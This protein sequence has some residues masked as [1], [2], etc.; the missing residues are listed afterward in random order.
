MTPFVPTAPPIAPT[1]GPLPPIFTPQGF[2]VP[3]IF[4]FMPPPPPP[5]AAPYILPVTTSNFVDRFLQASV[6]ATSQQNPTGYSYNGGNG[7]YN[8]SIFRDAG[9]PLAA[10][11]P[12]A[13][14]PVFNRRNYNEE[15]MES[16]FRLEEMSNKCDRINTSLNYTKKENY[17][18]FDHLKRF[19]NILQ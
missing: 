10:P 7:F 11:R 2:E 16:K 9:T 6:D 14:S 3:P 1:H 15:Q 5:M 19:Y 17:Q 18:Q 8:Y 4:S 12:P 13:P